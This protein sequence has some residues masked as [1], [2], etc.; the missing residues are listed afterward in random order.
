MEL[1]SAGFDAVNRQINSCSGQAVASARFQRDA[2]SVTLMPEINMHEFRLI[3]MNL[4][5]NL[6]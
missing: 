4:P 3:C 6:A 5:V 1:K 2:P